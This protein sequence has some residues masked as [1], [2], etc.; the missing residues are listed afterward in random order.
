[1]D[2]QRFDNLVRSLRT[3]RSIIGVVAGLA[4]LHRVDRDATARCKKKCGPCK[5]CKKGKC[6]K[7][8][9]DGT[10]C[11]SGGT[12]LSGRCCVPDC[13][14]KPCNSNDGCGGDCT[15]E[16]GQ[17]CFSQT[18]TCGACPADAECTDI[19]CGGTRL[20]DPCRCTVS[21]DGQ[22]ACVS[23]ADNL[24]KF[25]VACSDAQCTID[26]GKTSFCVDAQGCSFGNVSRYWCFP[27][28]EAV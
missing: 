21:V 8:L 22:P 2:G 13:T 19:P 10:P 9:P 24:A 25:A 17:A 27:S 12:C 20:G 23:I 1:M 5:R 3:R 26:Q 16:Q 14:D 15:C 11:L 6:R 7:K 18:G 28:C 4:A